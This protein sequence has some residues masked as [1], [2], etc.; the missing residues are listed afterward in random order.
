MGWAARSRLRRFAWGESEEPHPSADLDLLL[1][2]AGGILG[3]GTGALIGNA[4]TAPRHHCGRWGHDY[5]GNR[6]CR[7]WY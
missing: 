1:E 5:N 2:I 7:A 3:A 4:V 6:V